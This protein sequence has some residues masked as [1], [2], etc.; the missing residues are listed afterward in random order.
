MRGSVCE[1]CDI[2]NITKEWNK[3]LRPIGDEVGWDY[4]VKLYQPK[5]KDV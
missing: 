5:F 1:F 2:F 4:N 3:Y